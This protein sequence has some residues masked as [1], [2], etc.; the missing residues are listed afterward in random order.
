M[1]IQ[2]SIAVVC[3]DNAAS[4]SIKWLCALRSAQ[5]PPTLHALYANLRAWLRLAKLRQL[6]E[7]RMNLGLSISALGP[8]KTGCEAPGT[9]SNLM[10]TYLLITDGIR[11]AAKRKLLGTPIL[12]LNCT[13]LGRTT[14]HG[15]PTQGA[16]WANEL[17]LALADGSE[18]PVA[19]G[20]K[21]ANT[22]QSQVQRHPQ[23]DLRREQ[24]QRYPGGDRA[25]ASVSPGPL[26]SESG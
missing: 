7:Q 16:S 6:V 17:Q 25:L 23:P 19:A 10:P 21:T 2:S 18:W 3:S 1:P 22:T 24:H 9:V 4:T 26:P 20:L 11:S 12:R 15:Q 14:R 13:F 8:S 5:E